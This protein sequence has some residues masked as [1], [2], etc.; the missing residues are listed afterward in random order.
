M[1][2]RN[3]LIELKSLRELFGGGDGRAI[4]RH[5]VRVYSFNGWQITLNKNNSCNPSF[6]Q[7]YDS[8]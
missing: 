1:E 6:F 7:L 5:S 2:T 8:R 3:V 4:C